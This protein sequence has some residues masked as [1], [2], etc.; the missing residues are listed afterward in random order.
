MSDEPDDPV[1]EDLDPDHHVTDPYD[2]DW[3]DDD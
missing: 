2:P 3:A 1:D